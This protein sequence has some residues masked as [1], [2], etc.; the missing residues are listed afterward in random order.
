METQTTTIAL[1]SLLSMCGNPYPSDEPT[2]TGFRCSDYQ[3][4]LDVEL[5]VA[6]ECSTDSD[7]Q[8]VLSGTGCGCESDDMIANTSY[9]TSNFYDL[10]DEAE[11]EGCSI[12]FYTECDCDASAVPV[13]SAGTC[14][15]N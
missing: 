13:C 7:C 4:M 14:S 6:Q 5:K 1:M 15:W 10:Y 3:L 9:N 11:A 2:S 12:E 8:Q